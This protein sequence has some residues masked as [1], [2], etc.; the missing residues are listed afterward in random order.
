M[1]GEEVVTWQLFHRSEQLSSQ[2]MKII[3]VKIFY[4][5]RIWFKFITLIIL[6]AFY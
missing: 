4:Y 1:M 3:M 6:H 5:G 2:F